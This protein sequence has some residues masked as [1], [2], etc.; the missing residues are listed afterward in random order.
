MSNRKTMAN[1]E[2]RISGS[3]YN[4]ITNIHSQHKNERRMNK[5]QTDNNNNGKTVHINIH[6]G[7]G[8]I[9]DQL[10]IVHNVCCFVVRNMARGRQGET[11]RERAS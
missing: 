1:R 8:N 5:C 7:N 10:F 4:S 3:P 6:T 2:R 11:G 9:K